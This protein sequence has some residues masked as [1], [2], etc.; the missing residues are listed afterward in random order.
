MRRFKNYK[1]MKGECDSI[2]ER[3]LKEGVLKDTQYHPSYLKYKVPEKEHTYRPDFLFVP[4]DNS[5]GP[6][7]LK[8]YIEVK[9]RFR[10]VDEASKYL[11]VRECMT[12]GQRL[13]FLFMNPYLAMPGARKRKDGSIATHSS[14]ATKNGFKWYTKDTILELIGVP[15]Q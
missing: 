11:Y 5:P 15:C 9:G 8:Y 10:D 1:A 2:F 14:W 12:E 7:R 6:D 4:Y 13:V 3:T